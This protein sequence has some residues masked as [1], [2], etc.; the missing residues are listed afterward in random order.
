MELRVREIGY[1]FSKIEVVLDSI[2]GECTSIAA[3]RIDAAHHL[4]D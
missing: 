2:I 4:V 3:S 1:D